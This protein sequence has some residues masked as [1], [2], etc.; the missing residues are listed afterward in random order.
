M[1]IISKPRFTIYL[2]AILGY[3]GFDDHE[4]IGKQGIQFF[5]GTWQEALEK[6]ERENKMIFLDAY[7]SW[8]GPCKMM[9]LNT[10]TNKVVGKFYNTN[11]INVAIDM[12]KSDGTALAEKYN[13]EAYPTLL[14]VLADGTLLGK[15]VGYQRPNE[16]IRIA[17]RI[18]PAK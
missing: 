1:K 9:K 18:I 5:T 17:R 11:F 3:K 16:L 4:K 6:A 15:E 10:F 12:E 8:C 7:A 2:F 13:V 14:F